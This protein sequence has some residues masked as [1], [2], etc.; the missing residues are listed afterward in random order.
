[1][2]D[3]ICKHGPRIPSSS[4]ACPGTVHS[5]HAHF[6]S[7]PAVV[8][9]FPKIDTVCDR[10]ERTCGRAPAAHLHLRDNPLLTHPTSCVGTADRHP[11]RPSSPTGACP[12]FTQVPLC[13]ENGITFEDISC[14]FGPFVFGGP[15]PAACR[16][17]VWFLKR[18]NRV[19]D[20]LLDAEPDDPAATALSSPSSPLPSRRD[21]LVLERAD[22]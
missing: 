8:S 20:G 21:M 3:I 19:S 9:S 2:P 15:M 14:I 5:A 6:V 12:F 4:Y 7:L 18:W 1:M 17:M 22:F 11:S 13:P 10:L 16:M